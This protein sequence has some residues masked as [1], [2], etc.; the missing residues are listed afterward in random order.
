MVVL[1]FVVLVMLAAM[2]TQLYAGSARD[3]V[4]HK[5]V[6]KITP[7]ELIGLAT[8]S[9]EIGYERFLSSKW[10][11]QATVAYFFSNNYFYFSNGISPQIFGG[12]LGLEG[13]YYLKNHNGG[14]L[15]IEVYYTYSKNGDYWD[16]TDSP[17]EYGGYSYYGDNY[18]YTDTFTILRQTYNLNIKL[19]MQQTYKRLSLDMYFG[20]GARYRDVKHFDKTNPESVMQ[21][22]RHPNFFYIFNKESSYWTINI[23]FNIKIGVHF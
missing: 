9:F 14:Y 12:K 10:S 21:P 16:F 13:K 2:T 20:L 7:V 8:P 6:I 15:G 23:P 18:W 4:T 19:G 11:G 3:S 1:R 17:L 22:T 5:N